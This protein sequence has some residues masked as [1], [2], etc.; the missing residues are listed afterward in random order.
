MRS[1]KT[2]AILMLAVAGACGTALAALP[3]Q[4]V[5]TCTIGGTI[6]GTHTLVYAGA[7]AVNVSINAA[8]A[9]LYGP[10]LS[11]CGGG[12][13]TYRGNQ[14]TNND[15]IYDT[16][17]T[18]FINAGRGSCEGVQDMDL[19]SGNVNVCPATSGA[20]TPVLA[21]SLG[22]TVNV[23]ASDVG[24]PLCGPV[25]GG[26]TRPSIW[27]GP[28]STETR[29]FVIPFAFIANKNLRNLLP[30]S[31]VIPDPNP[32][33]GGLADCPRVDFSISK[34][35]AKGIYGNND[36]CDWRYLDPAITDGGLGTPIL[37]AVMRNRLSGT[38]N[39]FNVTMLETL[40]AGPGS[41]FVAGTGDVIARVN[42]NAWCGTNPTECG[43]SGPVI[44][45]QTSPCQAIPTPNNPVSIGYV[46]TD[47]F[48]IVDPNTPLNP[49]DD[50]GVRKGTDN[51]DVLSYNGRQFNKSS[52]RCGEYEYWS[53]ERMYFDPAVH[54]VGV[55]RNT[56]QQLI[57]QTTIDAQT[58]PTVVTLT[59]MQV[60]RAQDG[61]PVFPSGP[62]NA[63]ICS[64]P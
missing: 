21:S 53:Y 17:V 15:G 58:D 47:R 46:G 14:D 61:S 1:K 7:T 55:R 43:E 42:S 36:Y 27:S 29:A 20:T 26:F 10:A 49:F 62:F 19:S 45:G 8:A 57:A 39:N 50:Y 34:D 48:N 18:M 11:S 40:G 16:C 30:A 6:T 63:S 59:Q 35:K 41:I 60:N 54:T 28:G 2:L 64:Q 3:P 24:A 9:N 23:V 12:I 44:G 25:I 51:Y 32:C 33:P 38:R 5:Q 31:K 52:V 22:L 56:V 37:G 13:N 4:P